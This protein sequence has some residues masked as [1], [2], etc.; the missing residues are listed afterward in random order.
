MCGIAGYITKTGVKESPQV[1]GQRRR[2]LR[3]L[4]VANEARG[5]DSAGIA[6]IN[7]DRG[8]IFKRAVPAHEFVATKGF[9]QT[10]GHKHNIAIAHTRLATVGVVSKQ[11]AHPF[12][13]GKIL[14]IHN[15]SV[16]NYLQIDNRVAV[17]SE[18]I[19]K[20]LDANDTLAPTFKE[21]TGSFAIVWTDTRHPH[22]LFM[23]R[24]G[25]PIHMAYVPK[26]ETFFFNSE[27]F[28]LLGILATR[29]TDVIYDE[30]K[31]SIVFEIRS[32]LTVEPTKVKFKKPVYKYNYNY[33]Q[34]RGRQAGFVDDYDE[35]YRV[36]SNYPPAT[37]KTTGREIVVKSE[38]ELAIEK[39]DQ[40][41]L[42]LAREL[43]SRIGCGVCRRKLRHWGYY[44][45]AQGAIY[46]TLHADEAVDAELIR[47]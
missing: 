9:E 5:E 35:D 29:F 22:S 27:K 2:L 31:E 40:E 21:L 45:Q 15:G 18:V 41:R 7:G 33:G 25:N 44:S 26:I 13:R 23:V 11:N 42:E 12:R 36:A 4:L 43:G 8:R 1:R 10:L 32:D 28:A 6:V 3:G 20:L 37:R 19:F 38:Q 46:C 16:S 34:G 14:G 17:D 30:V 24:E 47:F 39:E